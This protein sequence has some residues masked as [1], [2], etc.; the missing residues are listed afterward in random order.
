[1][2]DPRQIAAAGAPPSGPG[3]NRNALA[4]AQLQNSRALLNGKANYQE[5]FNSLVGNV[6]TQTHSAEINSAAQQKLLDQAVQA[7][8]S[9]SGVNLDEEAANLIKFQQAYQ[10][11][12]QLINTVNTTF[13][14]LLGVVRR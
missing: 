10:A 4:L 12:A 5:A 11:A 13:D 6:G 3:D 1:L 14:T 8:D 7:R 2:N 9:V